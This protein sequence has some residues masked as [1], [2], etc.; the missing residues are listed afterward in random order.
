MGDFLIE[1][2]VLIRYEGDGGEVIIP[3]N[4]TTIETRAFEICSNWKKWFFREA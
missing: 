3:K 2:G 4:A 1:N